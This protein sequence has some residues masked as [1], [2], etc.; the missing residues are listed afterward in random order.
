MMILYV[1][2]AALFV[3]NFLQIIL[4]SVERKDLYNRLMARDYKEYVYTG[5]KNDNKNPLLSAHA[6]RLEQWRNEGGDS[7]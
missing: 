1:V 3:C 5:T 4:H 6:K 2:I 7:K